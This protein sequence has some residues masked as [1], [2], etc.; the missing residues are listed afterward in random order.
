MAHFFMLPTNENGL[1]T[2]TDILTVDL[3]TALNVPFDFSDVFLYSHGWWT[4]VAGAMQQYNKFGIEFSKTVLQG[5]QMGSLPS[6][7]AVGI[8]WPSMLS[9]NQSSLM[10]RFEPFSYYTMEKRAD[11]VGQHA[12]Y[13][14]FRTLLQ[15][16]K[17]LKCINL[18]G[19]SFGCKVVLSDFAGGH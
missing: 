9:E 10:N 6:H 4:D 17:N 13:A 11:T 5:S 2:D 3:P 7:L 8:H 18:I 19:H 1:I 15:N 16:Q 14:F 12:G